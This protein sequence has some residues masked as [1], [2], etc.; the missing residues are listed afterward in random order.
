MSLYPSLASPMV[1]VRIQSSKALLKPVSTRSQL[2][3]GMTLKLFWPRCDEI[4]RSVSRTSQV[5]RTI[6]VLKYSTEKYIYR[7]AQCKELPLFLRSKLFLLA[8]IAM[9]VGGSALVQLYCHL[10]IAYKAA[11]YK[12]VLS[13]RYREEVD[14]FLGT[15]FVA[16]R[17]ISP[18]VQNHPWN[19]TEVHSCFPR[20]RLKSLV[21]SI[22]FARGLSN[23][24]NRAPPD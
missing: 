15:A 23:G 5:T 1:S 14:A 22:H 20:D 8:K 11:V 13:Q 4:K 24:R 19:K 12:L 16:M 17:C 3:S 9:W 18:N 6:E 2:L 7:T 21:T 10:C